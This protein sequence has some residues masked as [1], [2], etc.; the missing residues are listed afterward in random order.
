MDKLVLEAIRIASDDPY[1]EQ[2]FPIIAWQDET[3][4]DGNDSDTDNLTSIE[5]ASST[6]AVAELVTAAGEEEEEEEEDT[7]LSL[8]IA[9][10]IEM[11][12]TS[13]PFNKKQRYHHR[14]LL[15]SKEIPSHLN[16]L[17]L[18]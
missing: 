13:S 18:H 9:S 4:F 8:N 2:S 10:S 7:K 6:R 14:G 3:D 1:H 17:A 16:C 11:S 5:A 15:R 12:I